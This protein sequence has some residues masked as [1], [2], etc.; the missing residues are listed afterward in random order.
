[1]E[2]KL[3]QVQLDKKWMTHRKPYQAW[4]EKYFVVQTDGTVKVK[5]DDDPVP[6]PPK[7]PPFKK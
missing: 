2:K 3:T 4:F 7:P 5:S 1:M 6:P